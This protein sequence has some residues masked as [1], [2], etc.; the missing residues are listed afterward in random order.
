MVSQRSYTT[1]E[2]I[3][4]ILNTLP[5]I[6]SLVIGVTAL[7]YLV[8]WLYAKE[9]FK[10]FGATWLLSELSTSELLSYS[11][12]PIGFLL[13][14]LYL[15]TLDLEQSDW[16][17]KWMSAVVKYGFAILIT[18]F[19]F[20][21]VFDILNQRT[22]Y[23]FGS[24]AFALAMYLYAV[25]SFGLL[26]IQ[27]RKPKFKWNLLSTYLTYGILLGGLYFAPLYLG[28]AKGYS[29]IDPSHTSLPIVQLKNI[30]KKFLLLH[31]NKGTFYI[32]LADSSQNYPNILLIDKTLVKSIKKK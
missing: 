16:T 6:A 11:V 18:I 24:H 22:L 32:F 28:K 26:V 7:G 14:F 27:F 10:V 3:D 25:S 13:F 20:Q 30:D 31:H 5:R 2:A 1:F 12:I 19:V 21:V 8:G 29:D 4:R 15:A 23:V 17:E 9:Y